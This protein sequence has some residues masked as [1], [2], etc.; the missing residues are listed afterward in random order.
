MLFAKTPDAQPRRRDRLREGARPRHRQVRDGLRRRVAPRSTSDLKQGEAAGVDST[1]TMFFNDRKYEGPMHRQVHRDVDRR[2]ARGESMIGAM[3]PTAMR[4]SARRSSLV[5]AVLL[6]AARGRRAGRRAQGRRSARRARRR[7]RRR[8]QAVQAQGVQ[9]QVGR[10]S[11]SAPSGASRARRSCRPGT[12]SPASSRARSCSSR[13]TSTTRSTTARSSTTSSS[14]KNMARVVPAGR[15]VRRRAATTARTTCRR[16]SSP[17]RKGVVRLV[18]EGFEAGDADGEY[19][20][21]KGSLDRLVRA[22]RRL[23]GG[24]ALG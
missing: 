21:F 15:Q 11:R 16:R 24:P 8:R 2:R 19:K 3:R 5:V 10:A 7:D 9:G 1:P 14:C 12:S 22:G 23:P 17:I 6:L 20:K 4:A 18:R 13:S